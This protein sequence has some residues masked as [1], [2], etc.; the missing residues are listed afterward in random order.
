MILRGTTFGSVIGA[1]GVQ[2]FFGEGYPYHRWL[3]LMFG[4]NFSFG[5]M[6]FVAKTTTLNP[7]EGNMHLGADGITPLEY[8]PRCIKVKPF[9]GVALNAVGL[10][11]P[12]AA[13]LL[14]DGRWQAR[15][16]SFFI[17]FMSVEKSFEERREELIRFVALLR[18]YLHRFRGRVGLQINFS[19]PNT[20]L[21]P[22][23]LITEIGQ[24]LE[25][26]SVLEIPLVPKIN[27]LVP[28]AVAAEISLNANCD[29]L[30]V[31]NTLPW[32]S[33]P[34]RIPWKKIF[35]TEESPL[36]EMGGGGLSGA[37]LLPLLLEWLGQADGLVTKPIIAGGGILG[38]HDVRKLRSYRPTAVS[39]GS[40]V[41]LRPWRLSAAIREG[42][43]KSN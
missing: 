5:G 18:S 17:S 31:S 7:R 23:H 16:D 34:G 13:A 21:N 25:I 33:L 9:K 1:S 36:K 2:G 29:A 38:P 26:A 30:C 43:L 39:L 35:G 28:P 24:A 6:T 27:L 11:G 10:S 8:K 37:P 15:R 32:G 40:I 14:N 19:C 20:G 3:R 22:A 4:N 12:G 41:M 42:N